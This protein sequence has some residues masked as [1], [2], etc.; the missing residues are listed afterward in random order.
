MKIHSNFGLKSLFFW[1]GAFFWSHPVSQFKYVS[2][3]F[4]T[5]LTTTNRN[6][7]KDRLNEINPG[8]QSKTSIKSNY[9]IIETMSCDSFGGPKT[10]WYISHEFLKDASSKKCQDF[11]ENG[12]RCVPE[13]ACKNGEVIINKPKPIHSN[14]S[15]MILLLYN[16]YSK[17]PGTDEVCCKHPDWKNVPL[18]ASITIKKPLV[19]CRTRSIKSVNIK[20]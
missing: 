11:S 10:V 5:G 17:C 13:Y 9:N 6:L 14:L 16:E 3:A 19:N 7:T 18:E 20:G 8:E 2:S 1:G 4:I 15:R 12:Y